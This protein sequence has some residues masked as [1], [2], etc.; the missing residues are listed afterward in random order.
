MYEVRLFANDGFSRI[1]PVRLASRATRRLGIDTA[2]GTFNRHD[3]CG[4][5]QCDVEAAAT[6]TKEPLSELSVP[7][8]RLR[9]KRHIEPLHGN[10]G[11]SC[12]RGLTWTAVA[13]NNAD[14]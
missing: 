7:P 10:L 8:D 12:S 6:V 4:A 1:A 2:N 5:K 3:V 9:R 14:S 11:Q 13:T